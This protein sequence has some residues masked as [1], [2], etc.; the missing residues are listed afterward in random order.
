M[1]FVLIF[2]AIFLIDQEIK[3]IIIN[4]FRYQTE[5]ISIVFALN[6]GVAFSMFSILGEY[7]KYLQITLVSGVFIYSI[8]NRYFN[9]YHIPL[10]IL[11]SA[12]I[13][14]IY[15]RFNY[16]GVVDYLYWHCGFDFAIFNFADVMIDFA[17][18]L[19]FIKYYKN[20]KRVKNEE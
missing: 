15:D 19:I 17:V 16:D 10:A 9:K 14:N 11:I 8:I 13:S 12:A 1:I 7:L 6:K 4:G 18:L 20:E 5:C 2:I 3:K